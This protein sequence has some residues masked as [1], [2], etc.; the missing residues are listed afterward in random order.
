MRSSVSDGKAVESVIRLRPPAVE[1]G[2]IESAIQDHFLSARARSLKRP[3]RI[4]EPDVHALHEVA[5]DIDVVVLN[6]NN[7]IREPRIAH[8]L[9]DLLKDSLSRLVLRM[10]L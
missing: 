4:V 5:A 1:H 9:R 10:G 3:P 2:K 8:Q 7:F 6:E